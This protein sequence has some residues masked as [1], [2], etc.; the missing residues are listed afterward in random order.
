ME[1][2]MVHK[3]TDVLIRE[4][5]AKDLGH[6]AAVHQLAFPDSALS[7]LGTEAVRRYYEWQLVGP[8]EVTAISA[9]I[10]TELVGFC[11]GGLFRGAMSGF[12]R[13]NQK[14]LIRRVLTHPW[15]MT[16]PIFRDR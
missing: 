12:V 5:Q 9:Y 16:N 11:F 6:V 8:H 2:E 3:P 10:N 4:I 14:F 15:L 7:M 1:N 13:N